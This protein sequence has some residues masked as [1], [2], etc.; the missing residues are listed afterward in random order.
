MKEKVIAFLKKFSYA[1]S[2]NL[3]TLVVG[4]LVVLIVP[5][6]LGKEAYGYWQ[7]YL[8]YT[9][10]VGFFHFGWVDGIYLSYGGT[11][12]D[13]LDK[14][15]LFSQFWLLMILQLLIATLMCW[16]GYNN[17]I[18]KH[19]S[20]IIYMTALSCIV[21]IPKTLLSYILQA[22][23]RIKE[24]ARTN[25]I[26]RIIYCL[27]IIGIIILGSDKYQTMI[28][29]DLIGKLVG[30]VYASY[31]C[32]DIVYLKISQ[33]K[34][35]YSE[36]YQNINAGIKLMFANLASMLIIGIVRFAIENRWDVVTFG[37]VSLTMNVCNMMLIFIN[38]I[39]IIMFP[40]LRR[41]DEDKLPETYAILRTVLVV[42]MLGILILYYPMSRLLSL[43]LPQYADGLT[44][45]A[46]LFPMCVYE[47]KMALLIN[48]YLKTLR[49]EKNMLFINMASVCLSVVTTGII[50]VWQ[51][52][53]TLAVLS[54]VGLLAFRAIVAET[55]LSKIL[56][57]EVKKD[58]ILE[59][60]MTI[61]FIATGW[62][63]NA[64]IGA[65]VYLIAYICYIVIKKNDILYIIKAVK[66]LMRPKNSV[67][68][69]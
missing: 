15:D 6:V 16:I 38:S 10:Y 29:A 59:L 3:I 24:Y 44:Y 35:C 34:L 54:I 23:G 9:S 31:C 45:M 40:M 69:V 37:K 27:L 12:Y 62:F 14:K 63:F 11:E 26:D 39:G 32:K 66:G 30:L 57:V 20:L 17:V 1:V 50:I 22:T 18:D 7:I 64:W 5:K 36:I 58:I 49:K 53:L 33:F 56:Q 51:Q 65:G 67:E 61:I 25:I 46:L 52:N 60:A 28:L 21:V 41:M 2:S 48:T 42:P 19:K 43:W 4:F 55:V 68:S 13:E 8:F 47:G